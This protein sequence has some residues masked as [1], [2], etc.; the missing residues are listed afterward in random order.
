M[1][2]VTSLASV[3]SGRRRPPTSPPASPEAEAAA[4]KL[5]SRVRGQVRFDPGSRAL[6]AKDYSN[7]RHVPIGVVVPHDTDDVIAAVD[8]CRETGVPVLA[9]GC[10][11]SPTGQACNVAVVIDTSQHLRRITELDPDRRIA[12]V[13]PGVVCDQLRDAAE[14]HEL[15]FAPDPATHAFC[16]IGGMI[17][18]NSCGPHSILGGRTVDNIEEMEVLTYDGLRLRVGPTS[19]EQLEQIIR[20]G[21]RRGEIYARLRDLRDRYGDLIRARYPDIPR[22]CSGYNLDDLLP[23]KGFNVAR[24]LVG[25]ENTCVTVLEATARLVPSPQHRVTLVLGYPERFSSGDHVPEIMRQGPTALEA[26]DHTLTDNMTANRQLAAE[27]AVLPEGE[28]WLLAEFSGDS[29]DEA[30]AKAHEAMEALADGPQVSTQ[31][32]EQPPEQGFV[33]AVRESAVDN[34]VVPGQLVTEGGWEDAAVPPERLGDYLRDFDE[35]VRRHDYYCVYYG[36]FGQACVHTRLDFDLKSAGGIAKFRSFMEEATDLVVGYGGSI[37]GEYGD[38][39][40]GELLPKMFGPELVRAF[41]EFKAIWDPAGKMNPHKVVD[42]YALDE[43]LRYGTDY[44]PLPV[45]THFG[46]PEDNGSFTQASERCFGVGRCRKLGTG[47]MC[48][49]YMVTLDERHTTRGRANLLFEMLR[50]EAISDGWRDE[51]VKESLDLCLA[52]KACKSECPVKVDMA[53]YKAEFLSHYYAGRLRPRAAYAVGLIPYWARLASRAPWLANLVTQAPGVRDLAKKA[54][55][56]APGRTLPRFAAQPFA[57]WHAGRRFPGARD[58]RPVLLWPDTFT[59]YFTPE[60][61]IAA[62]EVLE[63][64]GCLVQLPPRP[65]CCGRP[66]YDYGMLSLAKRFLRQIIDALRPQIRA[67]VPL[68]GLEP[69]CVA[70]FRDELPNLLPHD[71]DARRLAAQTYLFSEFLT[72]ELS[73]VELPTLRRRA[74]VQ[75][76]CHHKAVMGFDAEQAVLDRLGLDAEV[77]DSGCCG[78]AG[79]FGYEAGDRFDVSVK[80]GERVLAPAVRRADADTLILADGFSC[81]GQIHQLTGRWPLHVAEVVRLAQRDGRPAPA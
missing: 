41:G 47:T 42:P 75:G 7:Y 8:S 3:L 4:E 67:G 10:G 6:Y 56:V 53:T 20:A 79:S 72:R 48:P 57:R 15:T 80:A 32:F 77:L 38:A 60:T 13:Q 44:H 37:A 61:A 31:L 68:V 35:L 76:H 45:K 23:E 63:G 24:A 39:N 14:E 30:R 21:G 17:G 70:V 26:F 18:N 43:N 16:T 40:R 73:D 58:G 64:A 55:G 27:R 46:F 74:L 66:L 78:M 71:H 52:C 51:A 36:H 25:T 1:A 2:S 33:W 22:R 69:S 62:V 11:T 34:S 54:A 12:R 5:R 50:G 9:R 49:S 81:R 65:L 28:A 19:D 59:N 29:P